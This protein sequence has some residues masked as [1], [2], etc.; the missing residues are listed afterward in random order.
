MCRFTVPWV[1]VL[2]SRKSFMALT[3]LSSTPESAQEP[4]FHTIRLLACL[5][6]DAMIISVQLRA[7]QVVVQSPQRKFAAGISDAPPFFVLR[8]PTRP[9]FPNNGMAQLTA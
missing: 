2:L 5:N 8:T 1:Y 6:Q 7:V 9:S 3:L 4:I